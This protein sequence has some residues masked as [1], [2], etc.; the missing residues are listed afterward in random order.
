MDYFH[1][2]QAKLPKY[3]TVF[4]IPEINIINSLLKNITVTVPFPKFTNEKIL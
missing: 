3:E 4:K 2:C 1:P